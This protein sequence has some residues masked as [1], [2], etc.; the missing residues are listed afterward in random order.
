MSHKGNFNVTEMGRIALSLQ[1]LVERQA[2]EIAKL[3]EDLGSANRLLNVQTKIRKQHEAKIE[4]QQAMIRHDMEMMEDQN[5]VLDVYKKL[6][7]QLQR[8]RLKKVLD[9]IRGE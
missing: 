9:F 5:K 7:D 8:P 1:D 4:K 3:K 6:L 2:A